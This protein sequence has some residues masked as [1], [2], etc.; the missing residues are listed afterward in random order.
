MFIRYFDTDSFLYNK[1]ISKWVLLSTKI[2]KLGST[3]LL[4]IECTILDKL[5][6]VLCTSI[7]MKTDLIDFF[8]SD[9]K[10]RKELC[11]Q[12]TITKTL[13]LYTATP[14]RHTML[15]S[16]WPNSKMEYQEVNTAF[17]F[18]CFCPLQCQQVLNSTS[19]TTFNTNLKPVS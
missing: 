13:L 12:N 4:R 8:I 1:K 2:L 7:A 18:Q 11:G 17:P 6:K 16:C 14:C 15:K 19:L 9:S 5:F 10:E 3:S